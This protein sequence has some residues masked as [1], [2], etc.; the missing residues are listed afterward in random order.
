MAEYS[1]QKV[2]TNSVVWFCV[3]LFDISKNTLDFQAINE[4][5]AWLLDWSFKQILNSQ[6][7]YTHKTRRRRI[8]NYI[9]NSLKDINVRFIFITVPE[10]LKSKT[11]FIPHCHKALHIFAYALENEFAIVLCCRNLIFV[12]CMECSCVTCCRENTHTH[13][14]EELIVQYR[15]T[16]WQQ[17]YGKPNWS[18]AAMQLAGKQQSHWTTSKHTIW[19][20]GYRSTMIS[21]LT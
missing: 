17:I 14:L 4:S 10:T 9:I 12:I 20:R 6:L 13:T 3:S 1:S 21:R 7:L 2:R 16:Q 18:D 19:G 5:A 15:L 8:H 11:H